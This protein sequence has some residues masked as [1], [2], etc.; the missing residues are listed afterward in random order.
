MYNYLSLTL[1]KKINSRQTVNV[2]GKTKLYSIRKY[3]LGTG[4]RGNLFKII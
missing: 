2:R 4:I 3:L 1:H